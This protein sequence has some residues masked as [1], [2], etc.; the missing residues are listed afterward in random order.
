MKNN[1]P[2]TEKFVLIFSEILFEFVRML[3]ALSERR[4]INSKE[5]RKKQINSE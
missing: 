3:V 1:A 5:F 4:Q 2:L